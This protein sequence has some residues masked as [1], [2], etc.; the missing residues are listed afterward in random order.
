MCTSSSLLSSPQSISV[1][2]TLQHFIKK[3]KSSKPV[4]SRSAD[5]IAPS[6]GTSRTDRGTR[7]VRT[8]EDENIKPERAESRISD[9]HVVCSDRS[10][11]VLTTISDV[12]VSKGVQQVSARSNKGA[13]PPMTSKID[14][15]TTDRMSGSHN[16]FAVRQLG[17]NS[18]VQPIP[19]ARG[20]LVD[21]VPVEPTATTVPKKLLSLKHRKRKLPDSPS[22]ADGSAK[23]HDAKIF[24]TSAH[25]NARGNRRSMNSVACLREGGE[26]RTMC[27]SSDGPA[28]ERLSSDELVLLQ[29][30]SSPVG[31]STRLSLSDLEQ[32]E[33]SKQT[34]GPCACRTG[35]HVDTP[36]SVPPSTLDLK[37]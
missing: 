29:S 18:A 1:Q 33:S 3:I 30:Y 28:P 26:G 7:G 27:S 22:K 24:R 35:L 17:D 34:S 20:G 9:A 14:P 12:R 11:D 32:F 31:M 15:N 16:P 37:R 5:S 23:L 25:T 36:L 6:L 2:P 8:V 19:R 13:S 21:D 4:M 10:A